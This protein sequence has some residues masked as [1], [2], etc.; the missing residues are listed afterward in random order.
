MCTYTPNCHALIFQAWK[1]PTGHTECSI[2]YCEKA[3][4][5]QSASECMLPQEQF[6]TQLQ[7]ACFPEFTAEMWWTAEEREPMDVRHSRAR[8]P[9]PSWLCP[10]IQPMYHTRTHTHANIQTVNQHHYP[11]LQQAFHSLLEVIGQQQDSWSTSEW[12]AENLCATLMLNM[13][14]GTRCTLRP[15][16]SSVEPSSSTIPITSNNM[17]INCCFRQSVLFRSL[18]IARTPWACVGGLDRIVHLIGSSRA[19]EY[20]S[21]RKFSS[22]GWKW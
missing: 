3:A 9:L 10:Y 2:S 22:W 17:S 8:G 6:N 15:C 16:R 5:W 13:C 14:C 4:A 21:V 7:D 1:E 12:P 11:K 19:P 20:C 18:Q